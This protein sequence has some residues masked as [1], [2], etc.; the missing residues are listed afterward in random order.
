MRETDGWLIGWSV[1]WLVGAIGLDWLVVNAQDPNRIR[2]AAIGF[3]SRS[4]DAWF[5]Q[6]RLVTRC[7]H[8]DIQGMNRMRCRTRSLGL[9]DWH[10]SVA[11]SL[12]IKLETD[13]DMLAGK[14]QQSQANYGMDVVIGN[15]LS[16]YQNEVHL[17]HNSS[18]QMVYKDD[19][20]DIESKLIAKLAELHGQFIE[21]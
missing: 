9:W 3:G 21:Q 10:T 8:C 7:I 6:E 12:W 1:D 20:D 5:D 2:S 16:T 14:V 17:Y 15:M 13:P 19:A 11:R 4:K 18:H